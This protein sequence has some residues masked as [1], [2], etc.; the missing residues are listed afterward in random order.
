MP[1]AGLAAGDDLRA[2]FAAR[3]DEAVHLVA[4][5]G[6]DERADLRLGIERVADLELPGRLGEARDELVVEGLLD[7][8]PRARLAALAGGVV[9][10][11]DRARDRVGEVGVGEDD[12]R[13]LSP[14][15]ERDAA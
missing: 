12:V 6:G 5:L 10:R 9:D 15:L 1:V 3:L 7:Q 13:A 2:L 11:P 14:Q 8:D 4:V